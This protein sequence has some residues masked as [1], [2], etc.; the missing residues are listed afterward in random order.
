VGDRTYRLYLPA[1]AEAGTVGLLVFAHGYRG[2]AANEM[3]NKALLALA[4][5]TGM[6]LVALKS[7]G[8]DWDI[9]HRP[10]EQEQEVSR[11]GD[12]IDAVLADVATR[13]Q[14]DPARRVAAGFSAGGMLTWTLACEMSDRFT[15]FVPMSGTF[16]GE[17]PATCAS[18]P[19]TLVHI[20]GT[21]DRTV[22]LDGRAIGGT[23]QGDV[24]QAL[25]MYAAYGGYARDG[26]ETEAPGGLT[27]RKARNPVGKLLE[28]CTFEGGHDFSVERLRYGIAEA[29]SAP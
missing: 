17:I 1:A 18:P 12:Y 29:L 4:D 21:A 24:G 25:A 20:H 15:G 27:C 26:G 2:S 6:A 3:A 16:W 22:P 8:E 19:A 7:A 28:F 9:A 11:E 23:R 14:I 5:D 13:A 10:Q